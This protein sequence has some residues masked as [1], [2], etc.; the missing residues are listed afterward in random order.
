MSDQE[1]ERRRRAEV[2][3]E[4]QQQAVQLAPS[5]SLRLL[6]YDLAAHAPSIPVLE[7][8][9]NSAASSSK[10]GSL[11]A[12]DP[13]LR[14]RL[15]KALLRAADSGD[16]DVL[17]WL[18]N[19]A[20]PA[21]PHLFAD[22]QPRPPPASLKPDLSSCRTEPHP[23]A[24]S[25]LPS[26]SRHAT[27]QDDSQDET[28]SST[29]VSKVHHQSQTGTGPLV[30]AAS[31]GHLEAVRTLVLQAGCDINERDEAGWTA[32]MWAVSASN[33]PLVSFL[34][35]NGADVEITSFRGASVE[36]LLVTGAGTSSSALND[37]A[38]GDTD[39]VGAGALQAGLLAVASD[40]ELIADMIHEQIRIARKQRAKAAG[41]AKHHL[42]LG[43]SPSNLSNTSYSV[44]R[45][46]SPT[47]QM[48]AT[49]LRSPYNFSPEGSPSQALSPPTAKETFAAEPRTPPHPSHART[50]SAPFSAYNIG[51]GISPVPSNTSTPGSLSKRKLLGRTEREQLAEAELRVRELV[52]GRKRALLETAMLLEIDYHTLLGAGV[53]LERSAEKVAGGSITRAAMLSPLPARTRGRKARPSTDGLPSGCGALEVGSDP[54]SAV[55]SFD[56]I[57]PDQMLVFS[58]AELDILLDVFISNA[59]PYRAPWA[60]RAIPANGLYLCARWAAVSGD[61]DLMDELVLNSINRIQEAIHANH[62]RMNHLVFWLFNATLLL[63]YFQRDSTLADLD[64]VVND[65]QPLL[66]DL[67]DEIFVFVIRDSERRID[68][69][70]DAAMLEHQSVPGLGDDIRFEG[71]WAGLNNTLRSLAGSVKS[72]MAAANEGASATGAAAAGNAHPDTFASA[73]KNRRPLSQIFSRWESPGGGGGGS[74]NTSTTLP[75]HL[76]DASPGAGHQVSA[77]ASQGKLGSSPLRN[78]TDTARKDAIAANVA[79][80]RAARTLTPQEA[81]VNPSPRTVTMLLSATLHILQVYEINPSVIIQALSQIFYWVGCELFNRMLGLGSTA[82]ASLSSR[83]K[84]Y[85]CRSRAMHIRLNISALEDWARSNALPLS[86]V[87]AHITPLRELVSWLQ[88][89]SSLRQFDSLIMTMQSLRALNPSQMRKAVKEYRYEVG[90][91]RMSEECLQY[92]EQLQK[93][94]ERRSQ[95]L[96][97][98]AEMAEQR[99]LARAQIEQQVEKERRG[100][101]LRTG[102]NGRDG[103]RAGARGP[104]PLLHADQASKTSKHHRSGTATQNGNTPDSRSPSPSELGLEG[105]PEISG[106]KS[107][108]SAMTA[109]INEDDLS[110]AEKIAYRAQQAI[111]SLFEP[112]RSMND[113]IPPWTAAGAPPGPNGEVVAP[114]G[115]AG[116]A[117]MVV[118]ESLHSREMLPF[119]LPSRPEALIVTPG[120]AFGF[121]RGHFTGTGSPAFKNLRAA[122]GSFAPPGQEASLA[123]AQPSEV[124][125]ER[126]EGDLDGAESASVTSGTS[127]SALTNASTT[128]S[129]SSLY[130]TGKGF[131]AGGAWEPV[132]I[133]PDGF[134]EKVDQYLQSVARSKAPASSSH[135]PGSARS[136]SIA[137]P[138]RVDIET[139]SGR[140]P[141]DSES[142]GA[143][144][145]AQ[146]VRTVAEPGQQSTEQQGTRDPS[147]QSG[148][149]LGSFPDRLQMPG[150]D[151]RKPQ[152]MVESHAAGQN[153]SAD[154][155][156]TPV[157][158]APVAGKAT[159]VLK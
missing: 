69:I 1:Q 13:A 42:P 7:R 27:E 39:F 58:F 91:T 59:K 94:W 146:P 81:M 95:E 103:Q 118:G 45:S 8:I 100:S 97:D 46:S 31:S 54:M 106:S 158:R 152:R 63:H 19:P 71:E 138:S 65:Y 144:W 76:K 96:E 116:P 20:N 84:R 44:S 82:G 33:L 77:S 68:R 51:I 17:T 35:S 16:N 21:W 101:P 120:D 24:A 102:E 56:S 67:V 109:M 134:L 147:L 11:A 155:L 40:R 104:S 124:G 73:A 34:L 111:D 117:E 62:G 132:P 83:N 50:H 6:D 121:G 55:F 123:N 52:E 150:A 87:N 48:A 30:L 157:A 112:G 80:S 60:Q 72:S 23:S 149:G 89:Q 25:T 66:R 49:P 128:S 135:H 114:C 37:A 18:F 4:Q 151:G 119:A 2:E 154:S 47:K 129:R 15:H 43:G 145:P 153:S 143:P 136:D 107:I 64:V 29:V 86:I 110:P 26:L 141:T 12:P 98:A 9:C 108:E 127:S 125:T 78:S 105:E 99:R 122:A 156:I 57:P 14:Y 140:T 142:K 130:P 3:Q 79:S 70:L 10:S 85:L 41:A 133:L 137:L 148:P 61:G 38:G 159:S 75:S 115:P 36:D 113:Y 28:S 131:A 126:K 93:D 90:E 22:H 74:P 92:L 88:C 5:N 53:S 139:D 32:L